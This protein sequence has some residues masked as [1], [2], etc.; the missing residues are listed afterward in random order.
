MVLQKQFFLW[1]YT[2]TIIETD[3]DE[4]KKKMEIV[5]VKQYCLASCHNGSP[6]SRISQHQEPDP[7]F[8]C[9]GVLGTCRC[10]GGDIL[11]TH[12]CCGVGLLDACCS[13]MVIPDACHY[14]GVEMLCACRKDGVR[15]DWLV[16]W[17]LYPLICLP[18]FEW[19][20][21]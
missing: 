1:K 14:V 3:I 13:G 11:G 9:W 17:S 10:V 6:F 21:L 2:C 12:R 8:L 5:H 18:T 15:S 16:G 19:P 20:A 4:V 7:D